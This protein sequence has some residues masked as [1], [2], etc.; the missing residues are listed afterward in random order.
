[1]IKWLL[2]STNEYRLET[3]SD[4][5]EFH[6]Q[7]QKQAS[8]GYTLT[9][10]SWSEKIKK[11]KEEILDQYFVVKY[12]FTFNDPKDPE[13]TFSDISYEKLDLNPYHDHDGE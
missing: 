13:N 10:F 6:K 12:T 3:L 11:S 4:V 1:M 8:N 7:L 2:K 9:S 5:E